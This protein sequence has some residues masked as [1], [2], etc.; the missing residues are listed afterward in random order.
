MKFNHC[1]AV[2]NKD[3][4][5]SDEAIDQLHYFESSEC[6]RFYLKPEDLKSNKRLIGALQDLPEHSLVIV[7]GGDG[8]ISYLVNALVTLPESKRLDLTVLPLKAGNASDIAHMLHGRHAADLQY[9]LRRGTIRTAHA[10]SLDMQQRH[11]YF[12]AYA[13]FGATAYT[14]KELDGIG[15]DNAFLKKF[16]PLVLLVE[17]TVGLKALMKANPSPVSVD[18]AK[19]ANYYDLM[20]ING[21]RIAKIYK[22]PAKLTRPAYVRIMLRHKHPV[23]LGHLL[24]SL[25]K[26]ITRRQHRSA[27]TLRFSKDTFAQV[28]GEVYSIAANSEVVIAKKMEPYTVLSSIS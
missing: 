19:P 11:M 24:K 22:T 10:V 16:P 27:V 9:I 20:F 13:S 12:L 6:M 23:L 2:I 21:S 17:G 7:I 18:G 15:R 1:L 3:S 26:H 25:A 5:H 8:T 14:M 28:D 4:S